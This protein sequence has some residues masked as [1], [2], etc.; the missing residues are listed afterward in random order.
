MSS[1]ALQNLGML[2]V[3]SGRITFT[4][5]VPALVCNDE[6]ATVA[7]TGTGITTLTFGDA[8]LTAPAVVAQ[9]RKGT[10]AATTNNLVV[11]DSVSTTAVVFRFKS[12][13]AGTNST[14]DPADT[15]GCQFIAIGMRNN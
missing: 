4:T 15:D 12:D 8:F 13:A 14:A 11:T 1:A 6:S 5:G 9:Y 10:E 3:V 2:H 7:D